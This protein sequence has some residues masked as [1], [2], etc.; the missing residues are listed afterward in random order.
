MHPLAVHEVITRANQMFPHVILK[1]VANERDLLS[2]IQ[3]LD[4][5]QFPR[6]A[7]E[8]HIEQMCSSY[9]IPIHTYQHPSSVPPTFLA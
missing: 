8:N 3:A 4:K 7:G 6:Y 2:S 5:D 1:G 9:F